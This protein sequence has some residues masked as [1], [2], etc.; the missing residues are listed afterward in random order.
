MSAVQPDLPDAVADVPGA[1]RA[2]GSSNGR[3]SAGH[4][5][6]AGTRSTRR[7]GVSPRA[8][9]PLNLLDVDSAPTLRAAPLGLGGGASTTRCRRASHARS[10]TA[11]WS[12]PAAGLLSARRAWMD[13]WRALPRASEHGPG[14]RVAGMGQ[15]LPQGIVV[16]AVAQC[17]ARLD[18]GGHLPRISI[19]V[20][21]VRRAWGK[22]GHRGRH[23]ESDLTRC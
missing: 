11:K 17:R 10:P 15:H 5:L 23:V 16:M 9:R 20:G 7:R 8:C 2:D 18:S 13:K 19:Q 22:C 6:S 14:A 1:A 21:R 12:S 4:S 3:A